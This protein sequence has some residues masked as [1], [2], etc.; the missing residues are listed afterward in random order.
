M[1]RSIRSGPCSVKSLRPGGKLVVAG[2]TSGDPEGAQITR[3]F[4]LQ[5]QVLGSMMGTRQE[6]EALVN[7]CADRGVRPKIA[8]VM[9]LTDACKGFEL[10]L[11]GKV[12]FTT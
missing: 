9:P 7:Y 2:A 12:V 5:L 10:M 8:E 4:F 6:L 3:V 1:R 11:V